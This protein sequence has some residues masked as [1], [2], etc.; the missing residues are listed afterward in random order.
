[1]AQTGN[2][3]AGRLSTRL[4]TLLGI[5][6]P[7]LCGGLMWLAT[8]EYV[9]AVVNGGA[10]GFITPRSYPDTAAF[11]DAVRRCR[12]LTG[13]RP[14]GVNLYISAREAENA[15]LAE[16]IGVIEA[17][18]VACVETAGHSPA[19]ILPRLKAAGCKVIHKATTLRH[20]A[21]AVAAGA[22]AVVLIGAEAGGHPGTGDLPAMLLAAR[23]VERFEVPVVVGGGIGAGHQLAAALALGAEGV[24][25]G[26]RMLVAEEIWAHPALKHH[27][28]TLDEGCSTTVLRS[29]GNTYR[30]LAN[31]TAA[32]VARLEADGVRDYAVLGPLV[33][34]AA[35]KAAYETGDWEQGILSLGPAAA[36]CDRIEPA[37]A[38]LA[39][40]E[41]GAL[42]ALDRLAP[43][44]AGLRAAG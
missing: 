38:I 22:D 10:M 34:G 8:A 18:G 37:A 23:A 17:E 9:A 27:L 7:V 40:L 42:A 13:G 14:F 2:L 29:L 28:L 26:S 11:A 6:R 21:K 15:R 20:A 1:M 36:W 12:A 3:A 33:G 4:T 24:L 19:G 5:E 30:C 25:I 44:G 43:P 41:A 31:A 35:Q 39:R 16:W 32:E